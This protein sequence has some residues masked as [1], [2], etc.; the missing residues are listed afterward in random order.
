M[1]YELALQLAHEFRALFPEDTYV[2]WE[3]AG[4]VRRKKPEVKDIEHVVIPS[5][6][7]GGL[8]GET[9]LN[10]LWNYLEH[11]VATQ[12]VSKA[13]YQ[14]GTHRWGDIYRGVNYGGIKHELFGANLQNWG[15]Q[16][17]IRTGSALF[18]QRM[19]SKMLREGVYR[20]QGGYLTLQADS[21]RVDCP[22]EETFF[23]AAGVPWKNPEARK[24]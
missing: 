20:Q 22:D 11:L 23:R 4:S 18:S 1:D 17:V 9:P 7:N 12:V 8:F 19:V 16:L 14:D 15:C 6:C 13:E 21:S 5:I 24:G 2:R 10:E 3:I